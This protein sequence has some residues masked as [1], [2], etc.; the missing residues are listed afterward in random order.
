[1]QA[2]YHAFVDRMISR[3]EGGYGWDR[4]DPGGPT[5]YGITC[6]D[7]A[8]YMHKPMNSMAA[9]APIVRAMPLSTAEDI[10][11]NKYATKVRFNDLAAGCDT[12]MMD[13][14]VNSGLRAL[15]FA[16]AITGASKSNALSDE[17]V[18][19]I[20]AHPIEFINALSARRLAFLQSL[21]T[22]RTFG[23]GWG[24]RVADLKAYS[25]ALANGAP[26]VSA[27]DIHDDI[28]LVKE[29]QA[30]LN[31]ILGLTLVV[32]GDAG[33]ATTAATRKFQA[34]YGLDVD[35][36]IGPITSAKL[37][38]VLRSLPTPAQGL[39][40][41]HEPSAMAKGAPNTETQF[42]AATT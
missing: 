3:Y 21:G 9:W 5:K 2:N 23:V 7:L 4:G 14:E 41:F 42:F 22:W 27:P 12:E 24:R 28:T 36:I 8:E 33:P 6:Y 38:E 31:A 29:A 32:D 18:G 30:A 16:Q 20:N 17:V 1:M 10:Y 15:W 37:Q 26:T 13:F 39:L 35:G 25:L 19:R 40:S 11:A 34:A